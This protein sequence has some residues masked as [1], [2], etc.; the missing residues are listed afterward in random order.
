MTTVRVRREPPAFRRAEVVRREDRSPRMVRVTLGGPQLAGLELGLPAGSVRILLPPPGA[1]DVVLPSWNGNEFRDAD[2]GRPVIRTLTP[3]RLDADALELDVEIVRH[4]HGPLSAWAG[5]AGPG[6][7]VA[8]SGTGRGYEIDATAPQFLLAGDESALP[9][10]ATLLPALPAGAHVDVVVE[11]AAASGRLALP[12]RPGLSVHWCELD[13]GA[14]PGDA[15]VP[16]VTST[17]LPVAARVWAAGEAA[18]MQRI[19]RHLFDEV[20]LPRSQA[21]VRGYWKHGRAGDPGPE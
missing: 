15:L 2:G 16:R 4:G 1:A 18:A 12:S 9:A 5:A 17:R 21:V 11:I 20:G 6:A 7:P 3:L 10:I 14:P 13:E 8:V 19:R